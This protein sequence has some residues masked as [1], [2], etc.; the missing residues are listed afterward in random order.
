M[1]A[2]QYNACVFVYIKMIAGSICYCLFAH[3]VRDLELANIGNIKGTE[4]L[5]SPDGHFKS[6]S[7][8]RG[9]FWSGFCWQP[10][11]LF[12]LLIPSSST[13]LSSVQC[14]S[15]IPTISVSVC[16]YLV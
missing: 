10:V 13:F 3:L 7:F 12:L 1:I 15:A 5:M 9:V 4:R 2:K 14:V 11:N 6:I 8:V 16:L